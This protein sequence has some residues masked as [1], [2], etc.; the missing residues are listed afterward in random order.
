MSSSYFAKKS[1]QTGLTGEFIVAVHGGVVFG[2]KVESVMTI[3]FVVGG[4]GGK[5]VLES[6]A[7]G[8]VARTSQGAQL[9]V[10]IRRNKEE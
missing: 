3:V 4:M 6:V 1:L 10:S 5:A 7:R 2:P 9:T 8:A